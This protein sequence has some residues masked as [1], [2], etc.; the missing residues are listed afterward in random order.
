[1]T[2]DSNKM[3]EIIFMGHK[4]SIPNHKK[5]L[6]V[7]ALCGFLIL[8]WYEMFMSATDDSHSN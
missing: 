8:F 5:I 7:I 2:Q 3:S 4:K 6:N 1:M